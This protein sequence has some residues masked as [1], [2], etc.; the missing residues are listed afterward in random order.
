M[1]REFLKPMNTSF[2]H[3]INALEDTLN[4]TVCKLKDTCLSWKS[5]KMQLDPQF[6]K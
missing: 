4:P 1:E 6:E 3:D 2:E 5:V